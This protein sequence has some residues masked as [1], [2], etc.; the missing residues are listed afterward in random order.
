MGCGAMEPEAG[1]LSYSQGQQWQPEHCKTQR[2]GNLHLKN[3]PWV[4]LIVLVLRLELEP[5]ACSSDNAVE[6]TIST[7]KF[8]LALFNWWIGSIKKILTIWKVQPGIFPL[9]LSFSFVNPSVSMHW[10][11]LSW[12]MWADFRWLSIKHS[13]AL[14]CF[15]ARQSIHRTEQSALITWG[16]WCCIL[17]HSTFSSPASFPHHSRSAERKGREVEKRE[18]PPMEALHCEHKAFLD[19]W[20]TQKV[21]SK[22]VTIV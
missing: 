17:I 6:M 13:R 14:I 22:P 1:R 8:T 15:S 11:V 10:K 12:D 2:P 5:L 21:L 4:L 20:W 9:T 7:L 18:E 16:V 19:S 3:S